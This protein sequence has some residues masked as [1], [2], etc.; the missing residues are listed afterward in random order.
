MILVTKDSKGKV[1]VVNIQCTY[2]KSKDTYTINRTTGLFRGKETP[3]PEIVISEGKQKR[4]VKQQAKLEF[5]S[6]IN[7]YLSKGYKQ[8][9][10]LTKVSFENVTEEDILKLLG[11]N[12]T[13]ANGAIKP[14][15]AKDHNKCAS[16]VF[17][18]EYLGSPKIDGIRGLMYYDK[19]K[20]MIITASRGGKDYFESTLHLTTNKNI[21]EFFKQCPDAILDGELYC[22][23]YSL[24]ELSGIVRR[25]EINSTLEFWIYDILFLDAPDM[26]FK[27]RWTNLQDLA[28]DTFGLTLGFDPE[29][30]DEKIKVI[31]HKPVSGFAEVEREHDVYV[32]KGFEGIVIREINSEYGVGMRDNRMIKFKKYDDD[33]FKILGMEDR[34]RDEDFVFVL[35]TKEGKSFF[36]KPIGSREL[37]QKYRENIN[38][39]IGK[40]ATVKF[41]YYSE[42]NIPLQPTLRTIRDYE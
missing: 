28:T 18:K 13:D 4:T 2:N 40:M 23:G 39:I 36:A 5:E 42:D 35:E 34:L 30:H 10:N 8:Y 9:D 19:T 15:L 37:K 25:H 17:N 29:N 3:Q 16:K 24:Q 11:E 38:N 14:M 6:H 32:K 26:P 22:H 7:K 1:R 27:D 31:P 33:E 20:D 21:I 41:F 12:K